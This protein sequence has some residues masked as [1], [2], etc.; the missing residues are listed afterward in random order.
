ML[1]SRKATF[2]HEMAWHYL[3]AGGPQDSLI[4]HRP[5]PGGFLAYLAEKGFR[6][7]RQV[8]HPAFSLT[9]AFTPFGWDRHAE[10]LAARYSRPPAH[11][12]LATVKTANSRAF[13]L[14]LELA[15]DTADPALLESY[16][17]LCVSLE[18]LEGSLAARPLPMGWVAKGD[19]GHAGTANRRIAAYPLNQEERRALAGLF[20]EHGR[21]VLEPW[22]ERL[23]DMSVNFT[24]A[25]GG[26]I[27]DFRGHQLVNS[28]DGAFLGV[29]IAP[30][31]M[32]PE[33]W[34]E[35]L[36][37]SALAVAAALDAIGY[38]G[39]VSVDAYAWN[40]LAGPRLRP[41]V[42]INARH[43]MALP[44]H[45]LAARLPGKT[46][47][48]TWSKPRKLDLP[49]DYGSLDERLGGDAFRPATGRGI[50]AVSPIRFEAGPSGN[51]PLRPKRVGFLLSADGEEDLLRLQ[52]GFA[53]A[54]GRK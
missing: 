37:A 29:K 7:P 3:F 17:S 20:A 11:P 40:S 45:G 33:A 32:P 52:S 14:E 21:V 12:A 28:R 51:D 1:A 35:K 25:P 42:D 44:A 8:L 36:H 31:R 39:P 6:P 50:L 15:G 47:L 19:H 48:W 38:F 30:S 16:G 46:V 53:K 24:V 41:I 4:V 5:L 22:Q 13:S 2:V 34:R 27:E 43:S 10:G 9:A 23:M 18:G 49:P 54:L 26:A